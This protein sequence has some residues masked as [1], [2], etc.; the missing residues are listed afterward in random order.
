MFSVRCGESSRGLKNKII[1]K[2]TVLQFKV[3]CFVKFRE[4]SSKINIFTT[5]VVF[6]HFISFLSKANFFGAQLLFTS[7]DII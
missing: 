7:I 2:A 1:K 6:S 5:R 4:N 3:D